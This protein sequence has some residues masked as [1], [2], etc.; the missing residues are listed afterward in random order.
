MDRLDRNDMNMMYPRGIDPIGYDVGA[1]VSEN[2]SHL[3]PINPCDR[4]RLFGEKRLRAEEAGVI[5]RMECQAAIVRQSNLGSFLSQVVKGLTRNKNPDA[6]KP[7]RRA[8]KMEWSI[9]SLTTSRFTVQRA[10]C[11][12]TI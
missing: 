11:L 10:T 3:K 5:G 6:R 7:S 8:G 2:R 4:L 1:D 12:P 9:S